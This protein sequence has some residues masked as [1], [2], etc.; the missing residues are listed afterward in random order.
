MSKDLQRARDEHD[1]VALRC[2]PGDTIKGL[3]EKG[4]MRRQCEGALDGNAS[5]VHLVGLAGVS[6]SARQKAHHFARPQRKVAGRN[7]MSVEQRANQAAL[8]R[9]E[10]NQRAVEVKECRDARACG[11]HTAP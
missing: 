2:V 1:A 11:V 3:R 8:E 6:E 7:R 10:G 9:W 5:K 4:Q